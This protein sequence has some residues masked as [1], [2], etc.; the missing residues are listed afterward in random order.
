M[1]E[2]RTTVVPVWHSP[3]DLIEIAHYIKGAGLYSLQQFNPK[4]TL[5]PELSGVKPYNKAEL[6]EI[7]TR[8]QPYVHKVRVC[9][10]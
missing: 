4:T 3:E 1:V 5:D 7:A 6:D 2:F 10:L 9:N 8:C